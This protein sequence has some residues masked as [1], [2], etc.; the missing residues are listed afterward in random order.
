MRYIKDKFDQIMLNIFKEQNIKRF[1]KKLA[2]DNLTSLISY[3]KYVLVILFVIM[4]GRCVMY[5]ITVT[6]TLPFIIEY[7]IIIT[8][9]ICAKRITKKSDQNSKY[10]VVHAK[11]LTS[12]FSFST[13]FVAM[14]YDIIIKSTN[15]SVMM[16]VSLLIISAMFDSYPHDYILFYAACFA[17][18]VSFEAFLVPYDIFWTDTVNTLFVILCG[19][20][21]ITHRLKVKINLLVK[22]E[23]EQKKK[24]LDA[25]TK[26]IL[27]QI[28]PHFLYN[29]LAT[30]RVLYKTDQEKADSAMDDFSA[31]LRANIDN[32]VKKSFIPFKQELENINHYLNLERLRYGDKLKVFFNIQDYSFYL[33]V[34]TLQ[35]IIENAVKHGV[36]N[37][38]GGGYIMISA[39][40]IGDRILITIEDNGMGID[41]DSIDDIPKSTD[42]RAHLGLI[43]V[44]ER[45]EHLLG[46]TV[47]FR[48]RKGEG[49]TVCIDVPKYVSEESLNEYLGT[50]I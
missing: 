32:S 16:Y 46:G 14:Y 25:K 23:E 7:A 39:V 11:I 40:N 3:S 33:P 42:G 44:K 2:W 43:S 45:I 49:T 1:E 22:L 37:K 29:V 47:A 41:A 38:K 30:I 10:I 19:A 50:K 35:P 5:G 26:M 20:Y 31:Y 13:F 4:F 12:V 9:C 48:S 36:G 28:Q 24:L 6:N 34:L 8:L 15:I 18:I 21:L 27:G 17:A